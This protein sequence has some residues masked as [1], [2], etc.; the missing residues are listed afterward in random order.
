MVLP[1]IILII[2]SM[3]LLIIYFYACL[4][5]QVKGHQQLIIEADQ[6]TEMFSIKKNINE[7]ST[8]LGGAVSLILHKEIKCRAYVIDHGKI[9]RLGEMINGD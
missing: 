1:I 9:K 8:H 7:T 2:L 3:I 4:N 5:T 6:S